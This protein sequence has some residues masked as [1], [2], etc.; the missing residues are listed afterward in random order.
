MKNILI[1]GGKRMIG[2][3]ILVQISKN[4]KI[5]CVS[6]TPPHEKIVGVK[7]IQGDIDN[8]SVFLKNLSSNKY[9]VIIDNI[10]Y[11]KEHIKKVYKYFGE[12]KIKYILTSS[13]WVNKFNDL[14]QTNSSK[15]INY[16]SGKLESEKVASSL[17]KNLIIIRLPIVF[18]EKDHTGR[19][20][21]LIIQLINYQPIYVRKNLNIQFRI[22]YS[23]DIARLYELLLNMPNKNILKINIANPEKYTPKEFYLLCAKYIGISK[24]NFI[25]TENSSSKNILFDN[26][27]YVLDIKKIKEL[28]PNFVFSKDWLRKIC[29]QEIKKIVSQEIK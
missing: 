20:N 7:Y 25:E 17:W 13:Y 6:R 28:F 21:K 9:D 1:F 18:G 24:I 19:L 16:L 5:F 29:L 23:E 14:E 8:D 11:K 22:A 4:N 12:Q 2:N 15:I 10:A 26:L 3:S 27:D